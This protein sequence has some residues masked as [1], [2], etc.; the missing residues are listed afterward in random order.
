MHLQKVPQLR[1]A[2]R[3]EEGSPGH[4]SAGTAPPH[5]YIELSWTSDLPF[6]CSALKSLYLQRAHR[7]LSGESWLLPALSCW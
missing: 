2:A 1:A 3:D 6:L 5:A 4:T 7:R